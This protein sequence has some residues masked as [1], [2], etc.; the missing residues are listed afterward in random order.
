L[1]LLGERV[2]KGRVP[3]LGR[4]KSRSNGESRFWRAVLKRVLRK[5]KLSVALAAGVLVAVAV[6]AVGMNTANLTLDQEFGDSLPIVAAYKH[7][8]E[9]FPGG[10]SPAQVAVKAD[11]INAAPVR[12]AIEDFRD[13]AVAKGASKGPVKVV[14]H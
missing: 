12:A 14:F 7:M 2:E 5:P 8:D 11:D 3:F 10:P 6:P 9:A 4:A 1:S 13:E